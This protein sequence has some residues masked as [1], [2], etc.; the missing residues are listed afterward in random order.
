M[1]PSTLNP[2][3]HRSPKRTSHFAITEALP[4][5]QVEIPTVGASSNRRRV[6][7]C[8]LFRV[9]ETAGTFNFAVPESPESD[10]VL[11]LKLKARIS[12]GVTTTAGATTS[13]SI[14][15]PVPSCVT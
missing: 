3:R 7:I 14:G 1:K 4:D 8:G 15:G 6:D 9:P 5:A 11:K 10:E 13:G 2:T 12:R